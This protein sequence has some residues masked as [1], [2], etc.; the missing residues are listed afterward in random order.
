M[1]NETIIVTDTHGIHIRD[2]NAEEVEMF[3]DRQPNS[4]CVRGEYTWAQLVLGA[5]EGEY[6]GYDNGP[7]MWLGGAGF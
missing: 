3:W 5:I 2:A 4:R 1:A 7:G 6:I